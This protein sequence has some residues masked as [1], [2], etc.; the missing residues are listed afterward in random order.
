M[1]LLKFRQVGKSEKYKNI[2][3]HLSGFLAANFL[4]LSHLGMSLSIEK[5]VRISLGLRL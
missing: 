4:F 3:W 2:A 5:E 1:C